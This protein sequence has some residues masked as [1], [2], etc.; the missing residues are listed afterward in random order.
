M[1]LAEFAQP[2]SPSLA[3]DLRG[4]S[5]EELLE[6][7]SLRTDLV[8]PIP[9]DFTTL[10]VR[11]TS[12]PS[13]L[14]AI[15]A[16]DQWHYQVLT[17]CVVLEDPFTES[18]LVEI[19]SQ[20]SATALHNL[21]RA[22]L[23]Y[24]DGKKFRVPRTLRD[25]IGNE[26]AGLGPRSASPIDFNKLKEASSGA[27][28]IIERLTWG[29]PRGH[30]PD[31]RVKG[32]PIDWLLD[33][34]LL[35]P[36]DSKTV[37]LPLQLGIHLRGGKVFKE[38]FETQ[39]PL[40]GPERKS[41]VVDRAAIA[42][43]ANILRLSQELL[44]FWAEETPNVIQSGGIGVRDLKKVAEHL[45]IEIAFAA[46]IIE[47]C[48][49]TGLLGMEAGSV[50][51]T[52]QFDI[53]QNLSAEER[54]RELC[55]RWQETSR[56]SGLVGRSESRNLAALGNELDRAN[57]ARIRHLVLSLLATS[58]PGLAPTLE[59]CRTAVLWQYPHKRGISITAELVEWT[60][61]ESEW[62]GFSGAGAL[63][64][65]GLRFL[66]GE[67]ELKINESMPRPVDHILI[68]GDNTAIAPG[69]LVKEIA[70]ELSTFADIESRGN[71][72]VYRFS[73]SSI[74]RGLDHG[75]SGDEIKSFLARVSKTPTPQPLEYLISD[76]AKKHGQ[77][78]VG[79]SHSYLRSED[80]TL[81]SAILADKRLE[82]LGLRQVAPSIVISDIDSSL[83]LEELRAAGYYP[84]GESSRGTLMTS[85]P[86]R[87]AKT[88]P[89]PPR[90]LSE[91]QKPSE[92]MIATVIQSLRT[93]RSADYIA[94]TEDVPRSSA[95]ETIRIITE[96]IGKRV[97]LQIGYADNQGDVSILYIQ[98]LSF[99]E[100]T[101]GVLIARDTVSRGICPYKI[102]R[103]TGVATG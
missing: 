42:A 54:W 6:L 71:A 19:T 44:N 72:T 10:A 8:T 68:Q 7:L 59:S 32:G 11:A 12:G 99:S 98:P 21:Y 37:A 67:S 76:V 79:G 73:E 23:I 69:P 63:S 86:R 22:G 36:V 30:L 26:P 94:E 3:D 46:F 97:T 2:H 20:N 50:L 91:V 24:H 28:E 25:I 49:I 74:R 92:A 84:A 35:I 13:L 40:T 88:K 95:E 83:L 66:S 64:S 70:E 33:H 60:L 47:L 85:P 80:S 18:E 9:A 87:R 62:L 29:P 31:S 90:I 39:P 56:V 93:G 34:H 65:F 100:N 53:W 58:N 55:N 41:E 17:A 4:R 61:R 51:P 57:A 14:R 1:S 103:I 82:P 102:A 96:S 5:D 38:I 43:I 45:D 27:L 52:A 16:L 81:I 48:Y 15:D 75:H 77:L 78:R 89:R 101:P